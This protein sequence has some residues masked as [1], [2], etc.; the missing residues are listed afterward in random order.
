M[1]P[2]PV[3][4]GGMLVV[5]AIGFLVNLVADAPSAASGKEKSLNIKGAYLEVWA[6]MLGSVGVIGG[7]RDHGHW[8]AL[9]RPGDR[10]RHRPMGAA[11]NLG[12][13]QGHHA[14]PGRGCAQGRVACERPCRGGRVARRR[15]STRFA[16]LG[17]LERR[18]QR[19]LAHRARPADADGDAVRRAG[20]ASSNRT[21]T[22]TTR[23]SR[24]RL[25]RAATR[26][27]S[28]PDKI[29]ARVSDEH[30]TRPGASIPSGVRIG[31]ALPLEALLSSRIRCLPS[32]SPR[33]GH[34]AGEAALESVIGWLAS[35][36]AQ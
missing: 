16:S 13:A 7:A 31:T 11:P 23:P 6:D 14:D 19:F 26:R 34:R 30:G 35:C 4:S 10:H 33:I 18:H 29:R 20:R 25:R 28:T 9:D 27:N 5:A 32:L 3:S 15:G 2:E 12:A 17:H 8:L 36:G 1:K 22:F 24:P 21:S